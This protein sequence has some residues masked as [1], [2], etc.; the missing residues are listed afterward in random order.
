MEYLSLQYQWS[1]EQQIDL[2]LTVDQGEIVR[3]YDENAELP[4]VAQKLSGLST[5]SEES[6]QISFI[7][8][9]LRLVQPLLSINYLEQ[10]CCPN[11]LIPLHRYI[12]AHPKQEQ[13]STGYPEV[14][15][16]Y[17]KYKPKSRYPTL[18]FILGIFSDQVD[19]KLNTIGFI[20]KM[21]PAAAIFLNHKLNEPNVRI[22]NKVE[23]AQQRFA[24]RFSE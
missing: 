13:C 22:K 15:Q 16:L 18:K 3:V 19:K 9:E 7:R 8:G 17:Q 10:N 4:M 6:G 11:W 24:K 14:D 12:H 1:P 5:L 21:G 2:N 23:A 20:D